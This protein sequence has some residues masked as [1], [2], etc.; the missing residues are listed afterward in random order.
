MKKI[1]LLASVLGIFVFQLTA[2]T[3]IE[4][5]KELFVIMRVNETMKSTFDNMTAIM[6]QQASLYAKTKKDSTYSRNDSSYKD[7]MKEELIAFTKNVI[8]RDM[9]DLY[10]KYFSI[11]EIQK[12]IDFY[13]TPEGQKW[14]SVL[15]GIQKD[16]LF[17]MISKDMPEF[18]SRLKKRRE[19]IK[20]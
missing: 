19:E 5:I 4:K 10:A 15:P 14:I 6:Q 3:K 1:I 11:E 20:S 8:E 18:I 2:Q 17:N 13:K 12:Y 7:Y 9:V 16:L